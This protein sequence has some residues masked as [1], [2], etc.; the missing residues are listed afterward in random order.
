VEIIE[1]LMREK[2]AAVGDLR[3]SCDLPPTKFAVM[4]WF[5]VICLLFLAA[6]AY[7]THVIEMPTQKTLISL[8][9][10]AVVPAD[11]GHPTSAFILSG[12][13]N[14][15]K[16]YWIY[17][18][19]AVT[20]IV[21]QAL[22]IVR[23]LFRRAGAWKSDL[24]LESEERF[25]LVADTAPAL[26]W[27]CDKDGNVTYLNNRR[28]DFTGPTPVDRLGEVWSAFIHPDDLKDVLKTNAVALKEKKE[29]SKEY[30]LRRRD[31]VYRWVLDIAAPRLRAD[32]SFAGFVGSAIDITEYKLAQE[33]LEKIGGRLIAAQEK[34]RSRIARELH[35]DICQRLALVSLELEQVNRRANGSVGPEH[36][37]L[38]EIRRHCSQIADDVQALSHELHSSRLDSLGI[39]AAIGSFCREFSQ[40]HGVAV[41]FTRENVP[42]S[43]PKDISLSLFRVTQEAL[44]NALK[45]SGVRQFSVNLRGTADEIQLE[46]RDRGVGFDVERAKQDQGLGLVSMRERVHLVDG[47]FSIESKENCGTRIVARV[48]RIAGMKTATVQ[49]TDL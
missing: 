32:G 49:E 48:P 42:D 13:P 14:A 11:W 34:E 20:L 33:A 19:S 41:E 37:K 43:L 24:N 35:D 21:G 29:F 16:R 4:H 31:E 47:T 38:E 39:T 28:I 46:V 22:L 3:R 9:P 44:H 25:R 45:H 8:D 30:R 18:V 7:P 17:V 40:Q 2:T 27:M 26:V 12:E 1:W 23:L 10:P 15:R 6:P 36:G 5:L